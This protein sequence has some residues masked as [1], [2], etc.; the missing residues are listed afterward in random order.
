MK[1]SVIL[2]RSSRCADHILVV[3]SA[4]FYFFPR[5]LAPDT[6]SPVTPATLRGRSLRHDILEAGHVRGGIS[7]REEVQR[8]RRARHSRED[9]PT[10]PWLCAASAGAVTAMCALFHALVFGAVM[11]ASSGAFSGLLGICR[12]LGSLDTEATVALN[13]GAPCL[14]CCGVFCLTLEFLLGFCHSP[15]GLF[16][17]RL[18]CRRLFVFV[19]S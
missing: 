14:E 12:W 9:A 10:R 7:V 16:P 11:L 2:G 4:S 19:N 1:K 13:E 6:S 5:S 18:E 17:P 15:F 8:L 3:P